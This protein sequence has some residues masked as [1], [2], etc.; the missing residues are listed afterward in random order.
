MPVVSLVGL[1]T[2]VVFPNCGSCP[3]L[4]GSFPIMSEV[5]ENTT[6][7]IIGAGVAGLTLGNFLLRSGIDCVILKRR[8][9]EYA[10]LT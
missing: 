5:Q 1:H 9:R 3:P 7:V 4:A 6:V 10:G 8:D 2:V